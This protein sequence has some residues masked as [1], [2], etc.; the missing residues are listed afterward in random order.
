MRTCLFLQTRS[1]ISRSCRRISFESMPNSGQIRPGFVQVRPNSDFALGLTV[2]WPSSTNSEYFENNE[3]ILRQI[4]SL[5]R[6]FS[7]RLSEDHC[8]GLPRALF[9]GRL[10]LGGFRAE[11]WSSGAKPRPNSPK[12]WPNQSSPSA[13]SGPCLVEPSSLVGE[14]SQTWT[15]PVQVLDSRPDRPSRARLPS[16][17]LAEGAALRA[18]SGS[19]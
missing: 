12:L 10:T 14:R 9:P 11:M 5:A 15:E 6:P 2:F 4:T 1:S 17:M 3:G 8:F 16:P 19:S 13:E 18:D 7:G